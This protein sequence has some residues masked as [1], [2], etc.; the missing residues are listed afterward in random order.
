MVSGK[1]I[2]VKGIVQGV[3]FRPFIYKLALEHHLSGWVRNTSG[4]VEV[5]VNGLAADLDEF[6]LGVASNPP[7]QARIDQISITDCEPDGYE[8]FTIL[9]SEVDIEAFMP[10]S[11]DLSVCPDC[12]QELFD[13]QD[14]RYRY[15]FINCTHCGPRFSIIRDI[16]YDRNQTTMAA[17]QMCPNCSGEYEDPLDRRFHAQPVACPDCGPHLTL[18]SQ[19][20]AIAE[21]EDALQEAR[22]QLKAGKIVAVKGLGGFHLACDAFNPG[23]VE[24]LRE[25]KLRRAKPFALM[26]ASMEVIRKHCLVS[27]LESELLASTPSPILVLMKQPDS[28]IARGVAPGQKTLGFMLPYTPLHYLLLEPEEDFPE[29]LVMTSGNLSEEPIVFQDENAIEKLAPLA[30]FILTHNREIHE[31]LDDSIFFVTGEEVFPV[32]RSRG[33]TP[34]PL[35]LPKSLPQI[36]GAGADLKNTF[37][38]TREEYAFTSHFIGDLENYETTV[39]YETSIHRYEHLFKVKPEFIACDLHPDY[40]STRYAQK[41]SSDDHLPIIQVQHHHA[42]LAAC[43]AD[44]NRLSDEP[45]IGLIFDGTG[46]GTDGAIWGGEVLLGGYS[47]FERLYHL[48][49]V[50][51]PG[52]DLSVR[53]PARMAL[54]H[55][56]SAG[57]DWDDTLPSARHLCFE[58]RTA[59]RIQLEKNLNCLPTSSLGRLFDAVSSLI[60]ICQEV[61]Y[62]GQ[63]AIELEAQA[64][65]EEKGDYRFVIT[66]DEI[67]PARMWLQLLNDFSQG[68]SAS[69]LA[70]RF[71]NGL[72]ELMRQVCDQ[73]RMQTGCRTVVLSGGVWQNRFLTRNSVGLLKKDGFQVLTHKTL[74]ANDGCISLGQVMAAAALIENS[75]NQLK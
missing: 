73:V 72:V 69:V 22:R 29:A 71:Q 42:H 54:A 26:A 27:P 53:K 18:F 8:S 44:N 17:F 3:G 70:A 1:R 38:L 40:Y 61:T 48:K 45:V 65:P 33:L 35:R 25:R 51:L 59:L 46:L 34:D 9:N 57:I 56:S 32:R 23:A 2:F 49:Y 60:G 63:A 37:T 47:G 13:R 62:E 7:P 14:R 52:G 58:E 6:S 55:L 20:K 11:P 66:G 36:L 4:G 68:I 12:L 75:E 16:P 39:S 28:S 41:R 50:P 30:D 64:D 15:P 5:E 21:R 74:P 31:R 24:N 10:V 43:L 67:D 19:G